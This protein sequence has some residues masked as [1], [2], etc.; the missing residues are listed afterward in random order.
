MGQ[1]ASV[2]YQAIAIDLPPFGYSIPP[3]SGDALGYW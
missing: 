2:G 1:V 3:V